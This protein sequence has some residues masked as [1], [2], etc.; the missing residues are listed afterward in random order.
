LL[1]GGDAGQRQEEAEVIGE[2]RVGAGDGFAGFDFFGFK[3]FAIG[4]ENE[5]GFGPAGGRAVLERCQGFRHFACLGDCDVDIAG[6]QDA[7]EIGFVRCARAQALEG[8][9][10][11]AKGLQEGERERLPVKWLEGQV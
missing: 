6:L 8:G 9:F 10:L 4:S 1:D 3:A 11:V 7:A 2:I 5:A